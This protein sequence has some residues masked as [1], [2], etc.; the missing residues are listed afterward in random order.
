MF[1]TEEFTTHSAVGYCWYFLYPFLGAD[2]T[3]YRVVLY[4]SRWKILHS[5]I[6]HFP[7]TRHIITL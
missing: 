6:K 4:I 3:W 5:H 1:P 7:V 2:V